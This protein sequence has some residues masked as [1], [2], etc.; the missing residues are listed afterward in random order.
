MKSIDAF[1]NKV[2]HGDVLEIL[3]EMPAN[4]VDLGVTSPPY[5]KK[6]KYGGWLV[7]KVIYKGYKDTMPEEVYQEWQIEVLNELYR[8]TKEGGSFFYNHKIRYE[9]GKLLHPVQWLSRTK[10]DLWQEIIWNRKIAGNI[11]GWRFWQVEERIYWLSKG[12]PSELAP[13]HA[14]LSSIWD[15]R[16][17]PGH[18]DH[19]AVFPIELPTRIIASL[20]DNKDGIV[21]DPF[22]GTGTTLAAAKL[23]GKNYIGIDISENYVE[24]A[25]K[26]LEEVEKERSRV[27]KE[28]SMH[29]IEL[30]FRDRKARGH[31]NKKRSG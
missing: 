9:N 25:K 2:L 3:R 28:L 22:C 6:E 20:L 13:Q 4:S 21:I 11:R 5:N 16:P 17:E 19:P 26:R 23:L 27:L 24:Y 1:L 12:K 29:Y 18:K 10:W 31:W 15:I 8:V 14:K 7:D 30:T